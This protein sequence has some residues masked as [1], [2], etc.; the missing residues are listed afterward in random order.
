[1][2]LFDTPPPALPGSPTGAI[3][4]P[5]GI[6]S[7]VVA[8]AFDA[9]DDPGA[10]SWLDPACGDGALLVAAI[11]H[12]ATVLPSAELPRF[13]HERMSGFD[14]DP[15]ACAGA[16]ARVVAAVERIC[17]P[18]DP[19]FFGTNVTCADF[20]DLGPES[21]PRWD[22]IVANPPYVSATALDTV[23]KRWLMTRF[24][25]AWGRLDLYGLFLEQSLRLVRKGGTL[26]F[27]TP[28]KWLTADSSRRLRALVAAENCVR[29]IDRFERHDLF[30]GV[31]TV[32]CVTTIR[33]G[34]S[35]GAT[36]ILW[37]DV[38]GQGRPVA[39]SECD[40]VDLDAGGGAWYPP[41]APHAGSTVPLGA[42]VDRISV[43]LATGLNRAFVLD[44]HRAASIEPELLRPVI[45]GRDIGN[46]RIADAGRWL[47]LPYE[48]DDRG[49]CA[50]LI[51]LEAYPRA[52]A[53]LESHRSALEARH[54]VR[55][56][57]KRWYDLHDPVLVD[58][59]RRT[60]IVFPDVAYDARFVVDPGRGVPLHSAYYMLPRA[61][62]PG[63]DDIVAVLRSRAVIDELRR[64]APTAKSGYRR[65][66]AQV[67]RQLPLPVPLPETGSLLDA[68]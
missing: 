11:E 49:E 4:P 48:F 52:R 61:D 15:I 13:V 29:R 33:A 37:W 57:R 43:G 65:F 2:R 47:L 35:R 56:W 17:G 9:C 40:L 5:R 31:S 28:D 16:R 21:T 23:R 19:D 55:V 12:I 20:L 67:V 51:D 26:S 58:L 66:R 68:A 22:V 63:A 7:F 27:I 44:A 50:R 62:G 18:Q 59:A 64:R 10:G 38:D 41:S 53:H 1:M 14:I 3:Y 60:K 32:P 54:C 34:G 39:R 42:V 24:G 45:R 30:P 6:A 36:T 46:E 8:R 25:S